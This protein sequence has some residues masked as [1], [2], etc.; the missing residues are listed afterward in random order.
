MDPNEELHILTMHFEPGSKE[1]GIEDNLYIQDK[2]PGPNVSY[3]YIYAD[4]L[5]FS[6]NYKFDKMPGP[7]QYVII[8]RSQF[9][10][11]YKL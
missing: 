6:I 11:Q 5:C 4:N 2:M 3:N 10:F 1:L 9:V 7:T 8:I